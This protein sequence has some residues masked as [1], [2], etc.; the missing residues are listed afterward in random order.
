MDK[1]IKKITVLGTID[2]GLE[3]TSKAFIEF[4]DNS[5]I[6]LN[7]KDPEYVETLRKYEE[8]RVKQNEESDYK[9]IFALT[10]NDKKFEDDKYLATL[11]FAGARKEE[12][13]NFVNENEKKSEEAQKEEPKE[14]IH[15]VVSPKAEEAEDDD[16]EYEDDDYEY[17]DEEDALRRNKWR[18]TAAAVLSAGVVGAGIGYGLRGAK[19]K[20]SK[21]VVENKFTKQTTEFN[22]DEQNI[23]WSKED[24]DFDTLMSN[25]NSAEKRAFFEENME[26]INNF[27]DLSRKANNFRIDE[28]KDDYL[29]FSIEEVVALNLMM[30]NYAQDQ[31]NDI[32]GEA[33]IDADTL[34]G[35][36]NSA[37]QKL[38]TY[39]INAVEPSGLANLIKDENAKEFFQ[40]M[41]NSVLE[42]N[43]DRTAANA[44][45]VMRAAYYNY[46]VNGTTGPMAVTNFDVTNAGGADLS[47]AF[48]GTAP[49]TGFEL[50]TRN[51]KEFGIAQINNEEEKALYGGSYLHNGSTLTICP[52]KMDKA[53]NNYLLR[54]IDPECHFGI[55][56]DINNMHLSERIYHRAETL[57]EMIS[58]SNTNYNNMLEFA[59]TDLLTVLGTLDDS[60]LQN[61]VVLA[62]ANDANNGIVPQ[63]VLNELKNHSVEGQNI[64][65]AY[66]QRIAKYREPQYVD[67]MT[68]AGIKNSGLSNYMGYDNEAVGR[69]IVNRINKIYNKN[70]D[71]PCSIFLD[72]ECKTKIDGYNKNK[73]TIINEKTEKKKKKIV[74]EEEEK[75]KK[76]IIT[77]EEETKKKTPEDKGEIKITITQTIEEYC[78]EETEYVPVIKVIDGEAHVIS[79]EKFIKKVNNID[80]VPRELRDDARRG[81]T[82]IQKAIAE[83]N[84]LAQAAIDA[85]GFSSEVGAYNNGTYTVTYPNGTKHTVHD[86]NLNGIVDLKKGY[87]EGTVSIETD[88]E[89][90]A[91]MERDKA[92]F[93]ASLTDAQINGA[94]KEFG[95]S[96]KAKIADMYEKAWFNELDGVLKSAAAK[97]EAGAYIDMF[98]KKQAEL[99]KENAKAPEEKEIIK[100]DEVI[101]NPEKPIEQPGDGAKKD[102]NEDIIV[103]DVKVTD[104]FDQM[105]DP[106]ENAPIYEEPKDKDNKDIVAPIVTPIDNNE[107]N[108]VKHNDK[109]IKIDE[110]EVDNSFETS[111]GILNNDEK[112]ALNDLLKAAEKE[113]EVEINKENEV[114]EKPIIIE[115]IEPVEP[116][117]EY[118]EAAPVKVR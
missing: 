46:L 97:T 78:T 62:L 20:A 50:S 101:T 44:T 69:L 95:T 58:F 115:P 11:L 24:Y 72:G 82:E 18:K 15:T 64:A 30:N 75:K 91:R 19:D 118:E 96:W 73:K 114:E 77:E 45:N 106:Y 71:G 17:E 66:E 110:R 98:N 9:A 111:V 49:F 84:V 38:S 117:V 22:L 87:N 14:T 27:H 26:F 40:K 94:E 102:E 48:M 112:V 21:P 51:S 29:D 65:E 32:M 89:I 10:D 6:S 85:V 16:Y 108:K 59:S 100:K 42:F 113:A 109:D 60:S 47:V 61:S 76:K 90:R 107:S 37:Y 1:K 83:H 88:A 36:M 54:Y 7:K 25:I 81:E 12:K 13:V 52:D 39:Y 103:D 68:K 43:R 105:K 2:K 56:T 74:T 70:Y 4:E 33:K 3:G 63:S 67:I 8:A 86:L 104:D 31:I 116:I 57:E 5:V 99:D 41:E 55:L 35:N 79:E 93:M 28:D 34:Q 53:D 92:K 80:E 23:D